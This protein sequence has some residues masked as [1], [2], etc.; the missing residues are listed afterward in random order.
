M[1]LKLLL[2]TLLA[3]SSFSAHADLLSFEVGTGKWSHDPSGQFQYVVGASGDNLNIQSDLG[4]KE[5][6]DNYTYAV[7]RHAVPL[8][9]NV[10]VMTTELMH[11]GSGSGFN[12]GGVPVAAGAS[13]KMVLDHTDVTAFWNFLD[14]GLTFDLGL[15]AR[16]LD[17]EV[18]VDD[19]TVTTTAVD[20]TIPMIYAGFA[21]SPIDNLRF[22]VEA[23]Y[24]GSGDTSFT[25]TIA[26]VSYHTDFMLGVEAGVRNMSL[27]LD[28]QNGNFANMDFSGSFVGVSLKF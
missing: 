11:E 1:K 14:T 17:G 22:S 28:A 26:K 10:K 25:D 2:S 6:E 15:T 27:D 24:T 5:E 7:I 21:L 20:G 16:Q 8:F 18:T 23:N 19:G 4:Y 12:F 9:P 13:T 3:A